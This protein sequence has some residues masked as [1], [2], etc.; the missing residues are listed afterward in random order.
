MYIKTLLTLKKKGE[1]GSKSNPEPHAR[2]LATSLVPDLFSSEKKQVTGQST[3][4]KPIF[5][6]CIVIAI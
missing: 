3:Q 5:K 1:M 2:Q 4:P 6:R